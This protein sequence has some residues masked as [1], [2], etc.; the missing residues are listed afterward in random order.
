MPSV[1]T[2]WGAAG[3][4]GTAQLS[5]WIRWEGPKTLQKGL[6][7]GQGHWA[8]SHTATKQWAEMQEFPPVSKRR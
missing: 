4:L 3:L 8:S 1:K 2:A 7:L 5:M 6:P